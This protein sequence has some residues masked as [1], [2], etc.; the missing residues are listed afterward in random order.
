MPAAGLGGHTCELQVPDTRVP[1]A[2][3][4]AVAAAGLVRCPRHRPRPPPCLSCGAS[5]SS[6]DR[7][8]PRSVRGSKARTGRVEACLQVKRCIVAGT[9]SSVAATKRSLKGGVL[10]LPNVPFLP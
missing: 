3:T 5:A 6:L 2:G 9:G 8:P 1:L 7:P 10:V 4:V